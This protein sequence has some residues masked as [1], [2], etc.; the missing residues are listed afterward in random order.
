MLPKKV[1]L[2]ALQLIE[3]IEGRTDGVRESFLGGGH[4]DGDNS[5]QECSGM[6]RTQPS[7][8]KAHVATFNCETSQTQFALHSLAVCSPVSSVASVDPDSKL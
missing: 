4:G 5:G 2:R 7:L 8:G 3:L 6:G 1:V